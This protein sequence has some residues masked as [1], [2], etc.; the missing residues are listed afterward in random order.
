MGSSKPTAG[1]RFNCDAFTREETMLCSLPFGEWAALVLSMRQG[2]AV[3]LDA[4]ESTCPTLPVFQ[5]EP[6]R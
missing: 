2:E 4:N 1:Q 6:W 3:D 5:G